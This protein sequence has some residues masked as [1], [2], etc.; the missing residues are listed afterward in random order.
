[1]KASKSGRLLPEH[2]VAMRNLVRQGAGEMAAGFLASVGDSDSAER[3][4]AAL[5]RVFEFVAAEIDELTPSEVDPVLYAIRAHQPDRDKSAAK[6]AVKGLAGVLKPTLADYLSPS[7]P[8]LAAHLLAAEWMKW[9]SDALAHLDAKRIC[10]CKLCDR[11]FYARRS[12]QKTC[13]LGHAKLLR[14]K[15]WLNTAKGRRYYKRHL[16]DPKKSKRLA[17]PERKQ[18]TEEP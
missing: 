7:A 9:I 8:H 13:S 6:E 12:D 15:R 18:G 10:K 17:K 11:L 16:K 1:L 4:S 2:L 14:S 3:N 5:C